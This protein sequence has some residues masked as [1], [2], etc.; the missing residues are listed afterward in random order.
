MPVR[1]P[2]AECLRR[3]Q[4]R[5]AARKARARRGSSPLP[6]CLH[7]NMDA[8]A[9]LRRG[10]GVPAVSKAFKARGN[11]GRPSSTSCIRSSR[12]REE[13]SP[14]RPRRYSSD[15]RWKDPVDLEGRMLLE[16]PENAEIGRS[17]RGANDNEG[18]R[19]SAETGHTVR[20][21]VA[22]SQ[23]P[24]G[25]SSGSR[26]KEKGSGGGVK[27]KA[28]VLLTAIPSAVAEPRTKKPAC[29][30]S[31]PFLDSISSHPSR[32]MKESFCAVVNDGRNAPWP[33]GRSYW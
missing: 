25:K 20:S 29:G 4:I 6:A 23:V 33:V 21:P 27:K 9:G 13:A 24:A 14:G 18:W 12:T 11:E 31:S 15:A 10:A 2:R 16:S 30:P 28:V 22:G 26:R 5:A 17:S 19:S 32:G 8:G 7:G 1:A 3:R